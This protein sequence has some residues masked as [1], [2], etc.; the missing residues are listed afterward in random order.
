[1][2]AERLVSITISIPKV[3]RDQLRK[4]IAQSNLE[5]PDEVTS[6]S[7]L[8]RECLRPVDHRTARPRRYRGVQVF[9]K[10]RP[11]LIGPRSNPFGGVRLPDRGRLCLPKQGSHHGRDSHLLRGSFY[12]AFQDEWAHRPGSDVARLADEVALPGRREPFTRQG[13]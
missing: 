8:G 6:L 3:Y 10:E 1:M 2:D 7:Q 12:G 9:P 5:N 11:P 13:R 4:M